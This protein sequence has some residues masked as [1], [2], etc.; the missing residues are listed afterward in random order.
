LGRLGPGMVTGAANVDPSLVVTATVVGA[1]FGYSLLWVV[2]LCVPF[3]L[4]VFQVSARLGFETRKGLVDL[5]REHYGRWAALG[6]AAIIVVIN[7]AMIIADLMAVSDAVSI[8]LNQRR[9]FFVAA[10]AFTVWYILI[11]RDYRKITKVLLWL[12]LPLYVYV[13]AAVIEAPS[14]RTVLVGT[15]IPYVQHSSATPAP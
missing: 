9:I 8:I 15:I 2:V 3:L 4:A 10:I 11:F 7:M 1:T 5:L 12:S 6:C 13:A 14:A